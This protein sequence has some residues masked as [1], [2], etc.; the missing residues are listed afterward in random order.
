NGLQ[1]ALLKFPNGTIIPPLEFTSSTELA[2][3]GGACKGFKKNSY[4][5][6]VELYLK[7]FDT[8]TV[9]ASVGPFQSDTEFEVH[10]DQSVSRTTSFDLEVGDPFGILTASVGIAFENSETKG[11]TYKVPVKVGQQGVIGFTPLF[12]CTKGTLERCDGVRT[13][14]GESCTPSLSNAGVVEGD[15]QLI[16]S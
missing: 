13:D 3:R 12:Q 6:D 16:Q 7:T 11:V 14:H 2:E 4:I 10:Y 8:L 9:S 5:A 15:Y 1:G